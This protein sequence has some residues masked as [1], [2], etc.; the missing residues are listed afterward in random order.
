M[1]IAGASA[2]G[3]K[4]VSNLTALYTAWRIAAIGLVLLMYW[5]AQG[6]GLRRSHPDLAEK[7]Y[8]TPV[9]G[10][11]LMAKSP[12]FSKI[13][14][15]MLFSFA[16]LVATCFAVEESLILLLDKNYDANSRLKPATYRVI[17]VCLT[18]ILVSADSYFMYTG[19]NEAAQW[20]GGRFALNALIFVVAYDAVLVVASIVSINLRIAIREAKGDQ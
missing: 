1:S 20:G 6:E 5:K 10:F 4:K 17:I 14:A 15:A 7:V 19:V 9:P 2:A 18:T 11:N 8:K 3:D 16:L 12:T 13:D